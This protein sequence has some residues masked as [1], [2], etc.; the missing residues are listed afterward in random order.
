LWPPPEDKKREAEGALRLSGA[1]D[2]NTGYFFGASAGFSAG[3]SASAFFSFFTFFFLVSFF[4]LSAS[5]GF[6][7]FLSALTASDFLPPQPL[8]PGFCSVPP[9]PGFAPQPEAAVAGATVTLVR[10]PAMLR[11]ARILFIC[12]LSMM[13][14]SAEGTPAK[15]RINIGKIL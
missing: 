7:S 2:V 12:L 6:S 8:W 3:F 13:H 4:A 15:G 1:F 10:R 9:A 11:P 14:S 5:A